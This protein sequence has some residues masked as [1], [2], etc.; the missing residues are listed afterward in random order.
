[1][2]QMD[3]SIVIQGPILGNNE[4]DRSKQITKICCDRVRELMPRAEIILSTWENSNVKGISYDKVV[5]SKDPGGIL[6]T[7][8][9]VKRMNNTNR[10][11]VSTLAGLKEVSRKYVIKMRSDIYLENLN[12]IDKFGKYRNMGK[13]NILDEKIITLSANCYKRSSKII[14]TVNDWFEFGYTKDVIKIWD[15][16]LQNEKKLIKNKEQLPAFE[17]N[18]VG[19]DFVWTSFLQKSDKYK[20]ILEKYDTIIPITDENIKSY[21]ES[22]VENV[23][24]YNGKQLGI[25]SLKLPSKNY[26][27]RDFAKASCFTHSEWLKMYKKYLDYSVKI[28]FS[29]EDYVDIFLYQFVFNFLNKRLKGIYIFLRDNYNKVNKKWG[30]I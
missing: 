11:I 3:I 22:L 16:P 15:I 21:E 9:G 1:M 29:L 7:L 26:V 27:R 19:E 6:M 18:L 13:E 24:L 20:K 23:V 12:F 10:M 2:N 4:I 30:K 8:D 14:F 25:N 28:K 17:E 5:F